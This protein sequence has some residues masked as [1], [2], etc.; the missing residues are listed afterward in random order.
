MITLWSENFLLSCGSQGSSLG[1]PLP[2]EGLGLLDQLTGFAVLSLSF[3][4]GSLTGL[5]FTKWARLD[6]QE[7]MVC[8]S[9]TPQHWNAPPCLSTYCQGLF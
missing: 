3:H 7:P 4:L 2:G 9:P 1:L 8:F 6:G 5:E